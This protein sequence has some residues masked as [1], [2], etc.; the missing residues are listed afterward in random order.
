MPKVRVNGDVELF[1]ESFGEG[2][3]LLLIMGIGSQMIIWE[4]AFCQ[5]LATRG[6]RV[7]RFDNRD[8]GESTRM[9]K[10]RAPNMQRA[11]KARILGRPIETAYTIDDMANDTFGLMDALGFESAHV[12][13]LSLGGMIAQCMALSKPARVRSLGIL[14]SG[15]GEL[16]TAL[17]KLAAVQALMGRPKSAARDD[18]IAHFVKA[19]T[20][21]GAA[22]HRSS[23]SRLR[24]LGQLSYDR[25]MSGRGFARQFGAIM[26]APPRTRRL[27]KLRVPTVILH[28]VQDPL[29]PHVAGRVIGAQIPGARLLIIDGLG[30]ELGPSAWQYT[31][32]A[33]EQNAR[34]KLAPD[35]RPLGLLRALMQRPIRI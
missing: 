34:R 30:H 3:P 14:M 5:Q 9:D 10:L 8:V 35:A 20:V 13:G 21:L 22:P 29:I 25:G 11:L 24:Q 16:W 32:D 18:V 6:F 27:R 19:W 7:I 1:Y 15:P 28:G 23:D 33:L 26:A 12:V 17:P 31:I 4:D 2:E